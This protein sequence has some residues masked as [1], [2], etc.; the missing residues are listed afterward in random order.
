MFE[1]KRFF[2]LT[3]IPIWKIA[4]SRTLFAVWLPEPLTVATWMLKSLRIGFMGSSAT[5]RGARS[6]V[7]VRHGD[8]LRL[9]H[10]LVRGVRRHGA[11]ARGGDEQ[12]V[13]APVGHDVAA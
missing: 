1:G 9:A 6:S 13:L 7:K 12:L 11:L 10:V 5:P 2:P 4:R 8:A 3:G